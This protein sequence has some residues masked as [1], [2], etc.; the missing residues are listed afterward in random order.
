M[1]CRFDCEVPFEVELIEYMIC[2]LNVEIGLIR[3]NFQLF[4]SR[5]V[6]CRISLIYF[7][8]A[9]SKESCCRFNV[10]NFAE[11]G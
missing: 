4:V 6:C 10:R 7:T 11:A 1:H 3:Q 5:M 2:L 8:F 9:D